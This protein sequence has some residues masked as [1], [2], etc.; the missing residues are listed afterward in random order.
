AQDSFY[1]GQTVRIIV[2]ASAGGGYDTYSRTIARH[3][4]K[5]IPG[6]PTFLVEN[7]P[8]AGFLISANYMYKAAKPDGLTIGHFIGGLF[9]QQLL[10]KPGIEFD[11]VKFQF[12][13]VPTQDNFVMGVAKATG[14]TDLEKWRA[15]KTLVKFGGVTPGGGTDDIPKVLAHTLGLP[16]QVV[17]GYKGTGPI[18]LA[19]HSGEVQGM[20]NAWESLKATWRKEVESGELVIVTQATLRSHPDLPK[21]PVAS[22][23]AKNEDAVK[24]I[25]LISR[26]NTSATRPYLLPP[27]TPKELVEILR[28][29]FADTL[30]DPELLAEAQQ[31]K[32]DI[33]PDDG[34][35]LERNVRE[36]F[37]L[38]PPLIARLKEILK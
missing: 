28:K 8:G 4:G 2:G 18:R 24:M 17:T 16:L 12:I 37:K 38:D 34:A 6:N 14:I 36:I 33:N 10:G 26:V 11:A 13:G 29:G 3:I 1:K 31:A 19:F 20:C 15:S 27:G 32:L 35:G 9:L 22:T 21:V 30:R 23:L 25:Q 7:M 5:H